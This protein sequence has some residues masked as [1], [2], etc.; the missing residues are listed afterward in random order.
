MVST[1]FGAA[2]LGLGLAAA[3]KFSF[4][5]VIAFSAS[6]L[7]LF[8]GSLSLIRLG[9]RLRSKN[10]A[11]PERYASVRKRFL[12]VVLAEVV[13]CAAIAWGC[14][15]LKRF[16]LI[17]LGIAAVVGLHFL[18]LARTFRAP[19][20]YVTGSAIVIWCVV[21]WVLFRA[22]KMDTSVA[23]GTGAILWLAGGYGLVSAGSRL[24][25]PPSEPASATLSE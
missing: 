21:S 18:P 8:A 12:W 22:D 19:V 14:S 6:C 2:W 1:A 3:G 20:F 25:S 5:V 15:A 16:D 24:S 10:A 11:R 23:I 17:A 13:A 9:R 4:W 7:G